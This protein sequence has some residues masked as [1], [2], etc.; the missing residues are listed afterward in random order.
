VGAEAVAVLTGYI[1]V[2]WKEGIASEVTKKDPHY[3]SAHNSFGKVS[4]HACVSLLYISLII[5]LQFM[6]ETLKYH[7]GYFM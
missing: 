7:W 5:M 1:L 4:Q 6:Q 3:S 2:I